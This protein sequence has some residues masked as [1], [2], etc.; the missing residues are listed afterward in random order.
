MLRIHRIFRV[1]F[2][3]KSSWKISSCPQTE[4]AVIAGLTLLG[5]AVFCELDGVSLFYQDEMG[6]WYDGLHRRDTN[7]TFDAW[8]IDGFLGNFLRLFA[9]EYQ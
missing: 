4:H 1:V 2:L 9:K 5:S 8:L 7:H 3:T 6:G